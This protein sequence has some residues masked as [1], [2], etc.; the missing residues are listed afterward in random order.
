MKK[1]DK[2]SSENLNPELYQK[3][4]NDEDRILLR[5][6]VEKHLAREKKS[7]GQMQYRHKH[8]LKGRVQLGRLGDTIVHNHL[9]NNFFL[10]NKKAMFYNMKQY[11]ELVHDNVFNYLP[12]TFHIRHGTSDIQYKRFQQYYKRRA[13]YIAKQ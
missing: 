8:I 13:A 6:Y 4:L 3:I 7:Q 9:E 10:G 5:K 2:R 1:V 11:Y 12:L